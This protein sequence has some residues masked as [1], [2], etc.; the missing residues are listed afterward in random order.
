MFKS[1][2]NVQRLGSFPLITPLNIG[3]PLSWLY[4]YASI[5]L[6]SANNVD[7]SLER[8]SVRI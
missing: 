3:L 8:N 7:G 4:E 2:Y 6:P 5:A 1:M